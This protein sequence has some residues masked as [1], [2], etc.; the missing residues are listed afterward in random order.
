MLVN[1]LGIVL[2]VKIL[3]VGIKWAQKIFIAL[4][5]VLLIFT[6]SPSKQELLEMPL[7]EQFY[8]NV[9]STIRHDSRLIIGR[10]IPLKQSYF[11]NLNEEDLMMLPKPEDALIQLNNSTNKGL[12]KIS[13]SVPIVQ[14][15]IKTMGSTFWKLFTEEPSPNK[16]TQIH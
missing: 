16:V 11:K 10:I 2:S 15:H 7:Y 3:L 4:L 12:E 8:T 13:T 6:S 14:K 9:F 5:P 1:L